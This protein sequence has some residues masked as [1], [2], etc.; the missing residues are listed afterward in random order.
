M[1]AQFTR[2][3]LNLLTEI[4]GTVGK[5]HGVLTFPFWED[6]F[7]ILAQRYLYSLQR[8]KEQDWQ[9]ATR[10]IDHLF[11]Q[12]QFLDIPTVA[13]LY[14]DYISVCT[15]KS[16]TLLVVQVLYVS[17]MLEIVCLFVIP[18]PQ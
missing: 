11:H 15:L 9:C 5:G 2:S 7:S 16:N 10:S 14:S 12:T 13:F 8:R 1:L 3:W 6:W 4:N 18:I 17:S